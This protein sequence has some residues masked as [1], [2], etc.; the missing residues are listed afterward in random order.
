MACRICC[1]NAGH[2][3]IPIFRAQGGQVLLESM[4]FPIALFPGSPYQSIEVTLGPGDLMFLYTDG[5]SEAESPEGVEFGLE[6]AANVLC[7]TPGL[8]LEHMHR[9][10]QEALEKP[11]RG[12]PL[13][14]DRTLILVR[15]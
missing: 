3:P 5:I 2:N 9:N 10:L 11:T 8:P 15:R 7:A 14:D 1:T 6:G 4:G 12:A 13:T